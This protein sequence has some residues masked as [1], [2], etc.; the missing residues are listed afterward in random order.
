MLETL[1]GANALRPRGTAGNVISGC[2]SPLEQS[3]SYPDW[4]REQ[5]RE[6][7]LIM[8][9]I[10]QFRVPQ[11]I[12][13]R[14][15]YESY[16]C[17]QQSDYLPWMAPPPFSPLSVWCSCTLLRLKGAQVRSRRSSVAILQRKR[18]RRISLKD[19]RCR[20]GQGRRGIGWFGG[21]NAR[22]R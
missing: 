3:P 1:H 8:I 14:Q 12:Q 20:K 17:T 5:S 7:C 21:G 10:E 16:G 9:Q 11:R 19:Y 15:H 18:G 22:R 4:V 6:R 2:I 13:P